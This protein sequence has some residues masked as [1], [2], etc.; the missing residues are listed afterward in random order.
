MGE[1]DFSDEK[2]FATTRLWGIAV[3]VEIETF[4]IGMACAVNL[5]A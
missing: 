1:K 5:A 4:I 3:P 2:H